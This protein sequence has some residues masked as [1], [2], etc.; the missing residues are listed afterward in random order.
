M[1][2]ALDFLILSQAKHLKNIKVDSILYLS[3]LK[4]YAVK[5]KYQKGALVM[6]GVCKASILRVDSIKS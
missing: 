4:P 5:E 2:S 3:W 1:E 6:L